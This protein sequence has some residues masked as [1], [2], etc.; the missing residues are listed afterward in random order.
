MKKKS[1]GSRQFHPENTS[2][3]INDVFPYKVCINL[4]RRTDRWEKMQVKFDRHCIHGVHRFSGVDGQGLTVPPGWSSTL[5]AYGCL[6]SHLQV[7]REARELDVPSVLIFEDD[8]LFDSRLRNDFSTYISQVPPDWDMLHFG[9]LHMDDPIEISENVHRI[10]RAYS[11]YAYALK[12]T[13]FDAYL[14]LNRKADTAVDVNNLVLQTEHACYCFTPHLAW[15]ESDYSDAQEQQKNHWYL[16]ESLVING[17]GMHQLLSRTALIIA[18]RNP[19]MNVGITQN[20]LF[21]TRFYTERLFG[22]SVV[23]VEQDAEPTI[24]PQALPEGCQYFL[25]QHNSPLNKGLCFNTGLSISHPKRTFMIFS[26]CDIFV[27]EWD[28]C[29]NLRMCQRYDCTTGFRSIIDL[30]STDTLHLQGDKTMLMRWF[31][32]KKY[33]GIENNDI[34]SKYCVFK[35]RSIQATGGWAEQRREDADLALSLKGK[36]QLRVFASPNH[37]FRLHHD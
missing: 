34:F 30:T 10:R 19:T 21:L 33:S 1:D 37:A 28:I 11:T 18:Y 2:G 16:R 4:D 29:G 23:I 25:L 36:Q 7:V 12:H 27:E 15:V 26:D 8:V 14:E 6:L 13:I 9:A 3:D 22:I 24:N 20:L 35:R 31:N 17:G 5:G 32:A